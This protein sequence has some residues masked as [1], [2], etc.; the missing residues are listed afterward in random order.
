MLLSDLSEGFDENEMV[1]VGISRRRVEEEPLRYPIALADVGYRVRFFL[2]RDAVRDHG[3]D[4]GIDVQALDH[5]S[6]RILAGRE[7]RSRSLGTSRH[8]C[9]QICKLRAVEVLGVEEVLKVVDREDG[10]A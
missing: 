9:L 1:L 10:S 7:D 4:R 2:R 5:G 8:N 3:A 6:P